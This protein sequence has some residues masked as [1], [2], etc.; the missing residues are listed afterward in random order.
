MPGNRTHAALAAVTALAAAAL[1]ACSS[2]E[3]T[4]TLVSADAKVQPG[5]VVTVSGAFSKHTAGLPVMLQLGG[6]SGMFG[7]TGQATTTDGSGAYRFTYLPATSGSLTLRAQV[8]DGKHA[9]LSDAIQVLY[10]RATTVRAGLPNNPSEIALHAKLALSGTVLPA[11]AG[12]SVQL[13]GSPD[14]AAWT[15][16]AGTATATDAHGAFRLT[17]PTGSAGP[18]QLRAVATEA[19]P[20]AAGTSSVVKVYVADY[21]AAAKQYLACVTPGNKAADVVNTAAN[22]VD[23]GTGTLAA[24]DGVTAAYAAALRAQI[25]CFQQYVWPPSVA[26]LVK[27]LAAQDAVNADVATQQSRATTIANYAAYNS[28]P[29]SNAASTAAGADASKIRQALG[30]PARS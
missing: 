19:D 20:N 16:A 1:T 8:T 29:E 14:G 9:T 4:A 15:A 22:S 5:Q 24:L 28:N 30:L 10:L 18:L 2:P 7:D 21:Q 23:N 3:P 11:T 26:G 27:D 17:V 13:E 25:T 12:R 6:A